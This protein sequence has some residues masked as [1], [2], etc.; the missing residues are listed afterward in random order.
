[1]AFDPTCLPPLP[2]CPEDMVTWAEDLIACLTTNFTEAFSSI[3][4][5]AV[6]PFNLCDEIALVGHDECW[7]T[8]QAIDQTGFTYATNP[9]Q[10]AAGNG[11]LPVPPA[12]ETVHYRAGQEIISTD[13]GTRQILL[14][15][16]MP[17]RDY[18][19]LLSLGNDNGDV[20]FFAPENARQDGS[21]NL[22]V[23]LRNPNGEPS[24]AWVYWLVIK[25]T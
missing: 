11:V 4:S 21:F 23:W 3:A 13:E 24:S 10:V 18:A 8:E 1:M 17:T 19:V 5:V 14:N 22:S 25:M 2:T 7:V 16:P 15:P 9:D 6:P 20:I 12:P